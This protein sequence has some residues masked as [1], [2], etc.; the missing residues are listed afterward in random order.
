M[1]GMRNWARER[2]EKRLELEVNGM[3]SQDRA[4]YLDKVTTNYLAERGYEFKLSE[5]EE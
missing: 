1:E 5:G 2:E 3:E 4:K